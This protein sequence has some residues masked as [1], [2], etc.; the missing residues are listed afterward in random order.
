MNKIYDSVKIQDIIK[1]QK[2]REMG[3]METPT[4]VENIAC[5]SVPIQNKKRLHRNQLK[6]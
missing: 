5:A 6:L 2:S 1:T 4:T 3:E